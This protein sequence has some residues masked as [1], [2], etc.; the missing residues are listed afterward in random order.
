MAPRPIPHH[1]LDLRLPGA[2]DELFAFHRNLFRD[3]QMNANEAGDD[4]EDEGVDEN[5]DEDTEPTGDEIDGTDDADDEGTEALGDAGKKALARMKAKL[6]AETA[7]RRNAEK[8]RDEERRKAADKDKPAD[9]IA[10]EQARRDGETAATKKAEERILRTELR[11]AAKGK[12]HN[13][14]LAAKLL[15]LSEFTVDENGDVDQEALEAAI[16]ELLV[17]N[18][19]L[20]AQGSGGGTFGTARGKKPAGKKLTEADLKGMSAKQIAEAYDK[21]LIEL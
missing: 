13:P 5:S 12:M 14:A 7:A 4:T 21:G 17:E 20:A 16:D 2:L 15:D 8:E 10:L 6:K 3:G 11:A 18:P 1:G 9:Q 19:G